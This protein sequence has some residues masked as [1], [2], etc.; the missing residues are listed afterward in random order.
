[1]A[2]ADLQARYKTAYSQTILARPGIDNENTVS[3]G[4]CII[5]QGV[6]IIVSRPQATAIVIQPF[7]VELTPRE[8][9]YLATSDISNGYELG[10]TVGQVLRNYLEF[11]VDEL[12]WLQKNEEQLSPSIQEDLRRL[13]CYL[14]IM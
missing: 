5:H 3:K 12:F 8:G 11:L 1:M 9:G 13:Q 4:Y 14:R 7:V 10:V 2:I 6:R